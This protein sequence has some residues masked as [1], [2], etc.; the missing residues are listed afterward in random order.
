ML[1]GNALLSEAWGNY[2]T[3]VR[4]MEMAKSLAPDSTYVD[5]ILDHARH[6]A[7]VFPVHN[8]MRPAQP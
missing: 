3:E 6:L 8:A 7:S 4:E 5:E 1:V 2:A